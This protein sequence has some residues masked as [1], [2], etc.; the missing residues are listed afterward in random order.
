[1]IYLYMARW[2]VSIIPS[3]PI[4]YYLL[5]CYYPSIGYSETELLTQLVCII[6]LKNVFGV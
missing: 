6:F 1:M 5:V 4:V 3:L 2:M